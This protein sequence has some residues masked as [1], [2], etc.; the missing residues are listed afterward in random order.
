M[1]YWIHFQEKAVKTLTNQCDDDCAVDGTIAGAI[2]VEANSKEEALALAAPEIGP[3]EE[4][5]SVRTK[6]GIV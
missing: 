6:D 2:C 5:T 1:K 3:N 4:V